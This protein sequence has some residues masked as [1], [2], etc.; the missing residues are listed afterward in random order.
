MIAI[1]IALI[2]ILIIYL[3]IFNKK[4]FLS[5]SLICCYMFFLASCAAFAGNGIW[6]VRISFG[7]ILCIF[8]FL[9]CVAVGESISKPIS[10]KTSFG[11]FFTSKSDASEHVY[12]KVNVVSLLVL[13]GIEGITF[14]KYYNLIYSFAVAHGNI[15]STSLMLKYYRIGLNNG[16]A[17]KMSFLLTQSIQLC[18]FLSYVF[19]YILINNFLYY[20]KVNLLMIIYVAISWG[21][22]GL[23]S[24][25]GGYIN[26]I[27]AYLLLYFCSIMKKNRWKFREI[28]IKTIIISILAIITFFYLFSYLGT[29]T[30]KTQ[31][32]NGAINQI[33]T[34]A[35]GSIV[36]FDSF[37]NNYSFVGADAEPKET[38]SGITDFLSYFG[39][40]FEKR[41]VNLQFVKIGSLSTNVYTAIRRY[42]HDFSFLG[43]PLI[44][45]LI[46]LFYGSWYKKVKL[47][48]TDFSFVTLAYAGLAYPLFYISTDDMFFRGVFSIGTIYML[49]Y[50]SLAWIW[51]KYKI[52][53]SKR[54]YTSACVN[55]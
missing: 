21:I 9:I 30:G 23:S 27:S 47:E 17:L 3:L 52:K 45:I 25:R 46:G 19:V 15:F 5:P 35:G 18:K 37:V 14:Y 22:Y 55:D 10:I 38:L 40:V 34:Y 42:I 32:S 31:Q 29:F 11:Y 39:L 49:L 48:K 33:T 8:F 2:S 7:S 26:F 51:L 43:I 16:D 54:R 4:D 44:G 1:L 24:S 36:A 53:K 28:K 12:I 6:K 13:I 50:F 20:K 41:V